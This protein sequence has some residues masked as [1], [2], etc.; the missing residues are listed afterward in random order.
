MRRVQAGAPLTVSAQNWLSVYFVSNFSRRLLSVFPLSSLPLSI[1]I[2][3][4]F[5]FLPVCASSWRI[6]SAQTAK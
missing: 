3:V 6:N 2:F 1:P 4:S 5:L